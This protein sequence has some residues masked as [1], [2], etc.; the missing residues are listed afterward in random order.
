ML[1]LC[2]IVAGNSVWA[3]QSEHDQVLVVEVPGKPLDVVKVAKIETDETV[4][5]ATDLSGNRRA[6]Q[7]DFILASLPALPENRSGLDVDSVK[8]AINRYQQ[9]LEIRP[10]AKPKLDAHLQAWKQVLDD[11]NREA[12]E[13]AARE[14]AERA[15]Q[16]KLWNVKADAF[17]ARPYEITQTYSIQDLKD[18]IQQGSEI[19]PHLP[20][21]SETIQRKLHLWKSH[22]ENLQ[23]GNVIHEGRWISSADLKQIEY[24][25]EQAAQNAFL[26]ELELKMSALVFSPSTVWMMTGVVIFGFL[27]SFVMCGQMI[28]SRARGESL[29]VIQFCLLTVLA[30]VLLLYGYVGFR[31]V[32]DPATIAAYLDTDQEKLVSPEQPKLRRTLFVSSEPEALVLDASDIEVQ[33]SD[34]EINGLLQDKVQLVSSGNGG[35]FVAE[36]EDIFL[37]LTSRNV[38]FYEQIRLFGRSFL[39]RYE[40]THEIQDNILTFQGVD[41]YLGNLPLPARLKSMLWMNLRSDLAQLF[42]NTGISRHYQLAGLKSGSLKLIMVEGS[43]SSGDYFTQSATH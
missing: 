41:V 5:I 16:L 12:T 30:G 20:D 24:E 32:T 3:D 8:S 21:R 7:L 36:R 31:C 2:S 15:I 28:I 27:V 18:V 11:L 23:A 33:L 35:I 25:E 42:Q 1:L 14:A 6:W 13:Q 43:R 40:L 19:V 10:D 9:I 29:S 17:L 39:I 38:I 4:A 22:L 26:S 34:L 37:E